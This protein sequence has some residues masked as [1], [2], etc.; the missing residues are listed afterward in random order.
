MGL[1]AA[2]VQTLVFCCDMVVVPCGADLR[3]RGFWILSPSPPWG[4]GVH[5]PPLGVPITRSRPRRAFASPGTLCF[6]GVQA[7]FIRKQTAVSESELARRGLALARGPSPWCG[8]PAARRAELCSA[9]VRVPLESLRAVLVGQRNSISGGL[10]LGSG[11]AVYVLQ[12]TLVRAWM[13]D[14]I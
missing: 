7:S 4:G 13:R 10:R 12:G 11:E 1:P 6:L 5:R 14:Q 2:G 9:P 8:P 3:R